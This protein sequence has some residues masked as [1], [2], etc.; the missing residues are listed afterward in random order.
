MKTIKLLESFEWSQ[1]QK[2]RLIDV[3]D[4]LAVGISPDVLSGQVPMKVVHRQTQKKRG[5]Y[6]RHFKEGKNKSKCR[7]CEA[8]FTGKHH[9]VAAMTHLRRSHRDVWRKR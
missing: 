5:L 6:L 4:G 9:R 3:G 2:G 7:R 1:L 8:V